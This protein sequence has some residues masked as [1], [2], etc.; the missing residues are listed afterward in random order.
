MPE[1]RLARRWRR[2]A[3]E[4][5]HRTRERLAFYGAIAP[6]TRRAERFGSF[7]PGSVV[8]YPIGAIYGEP[9][10]H[11]GATSMISPQV[12]LTAGYSPEQTT[13]PPRALVIGDRA[14]IGVRSAIIAHESIVIG[15]DVWFGPEVFVTDANHGYQ[16]PEVPIGRQ[17]G[18]HEAVEIGSGSWLG[19]RAV[20]LP[21]T[22]IGRQCVIAAG[23]VVRGDIP[24]HSVVAGVPGRI[25]RQY[26]PGLGW[27]RIDLGVDADGLPIGFDAKAVTEEMDPD[28]VDVSDLDPALAELQAEL[29]RYR[30]NPVPFGHVPP[31]VPGRTTD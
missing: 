11:L 1:G 22:R 13:V 28:A 7:G 5:I 17:L 18:L 26:R 27:P 29:D 16:D 4:A 10:I 25:L 6:G 23:S 20:V 15:D 12:T 8:A 24:D 3:N 14:V 2:F 21:G 31:S 19:C 30:N 9:H